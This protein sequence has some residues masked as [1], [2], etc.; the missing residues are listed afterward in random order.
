M[1]ESRET[2]ELQ[3]SVAQIA[4]RLDWTH[5]KSGVSRGR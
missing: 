3:L 4:G 5:P 2:P 1:K